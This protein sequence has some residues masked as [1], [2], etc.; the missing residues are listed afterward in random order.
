MSVNT[1][2][3]RELQSLA[4]VAATV[5]S[6]PP[7]ARSWDISSQLETA[8]EVK[9]STYVPELVVDEVSQTPCREFEVES[10]QIY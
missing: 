7:Y 8:M 10:R 6:L 9:P 3:L 4:F 5:L 1:A 2:W